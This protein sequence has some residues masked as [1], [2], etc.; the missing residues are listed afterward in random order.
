MA[1][2]TLKL[3][4]LYKATLHG[5]STDEFDKH[6][7]GEENCFVIITSEYKKRFGGYRTIPFIRKSYNYKKDMKSFIFSLDF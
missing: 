2:K 6:C 5:T 4:L 7:K 1:E 3:Q